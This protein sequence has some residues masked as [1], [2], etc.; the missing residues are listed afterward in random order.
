MAKVSE[1][2]DMIVE[3]QVENAKLQVQTGNCPFAFFQVSD[4]K[5][6]GCDVNVDCDQCAMNFW[7]QF[8]KD[9]ATEV[10]AM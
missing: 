5:N 3:L 8:R 10:R 6:C 4:K 7:E 2:K 9:R 1:L